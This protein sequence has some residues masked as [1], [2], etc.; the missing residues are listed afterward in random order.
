[1]E[2]FVNHHQNNNSLR[3]QVQHTRNPTAFSLL[4][5]FGESR[6]GDERGLQ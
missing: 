2:S 5:P 6:I 3:T 4:S 1:M